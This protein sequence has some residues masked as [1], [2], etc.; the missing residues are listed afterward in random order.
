[1]GLAE[2]P[3]ALLVS[4]AL[5]AGIAIGCGPDDDSVEDLSGSP[6]GTG[7]AIVSPSVQAAAD[8]ITVSLSNW[9]LEPSSNTAKA[10]T[11]RFKAVHEDVADGSVGGATHQLVVAR[12]SEGAQIG[13]AN[14][15]PPVL[16]LAEIKVG[17]EKTGE[18]Q[19]ERGR[20]ELSC[21][22]V[23]EVQGEDIS[24]YEEGMYA[25]LVVE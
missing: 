15:G 19:L 17:E 10:G 25:L 5:L 14:F 2:K 24:H 1:M 7:A 3:L 22:V 12:L 16:N 9:T 8:S 11:V 4:T 20:Y 23:E 13:E 18:A 21:L 6:A